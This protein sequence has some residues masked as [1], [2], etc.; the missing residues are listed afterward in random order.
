MNQWSNEAM[1]WWIQGLDSQ[2]KPDCEVIYK[3]MKQW[4]NELMNPRTGLPTEAWLWSNL[5]INE[6]MNQWINESM[7]QWINESMNP[8]TWLPTEA[9]SWTNP[10]KAPN[11]RVIINECEV[12]PSTQNFFLTY[13]KIPR[14]LLTLRKGRT[15]IIGIKIKKKL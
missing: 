15:P 4:I 3:S 8:R 1:N 7:S 13:Q 9:W 14:E 6:S 2:Q 12:A 10:T 5:W 11:I